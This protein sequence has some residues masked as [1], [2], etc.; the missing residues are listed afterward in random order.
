MITADQFEQ[1]AILWLRDTG[2]GYTHGPTMAPDGPAPERNID[3]K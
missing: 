3:L 2:W 1:C